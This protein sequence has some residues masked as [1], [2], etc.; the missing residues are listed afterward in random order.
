MGNSKNK[1]MDMLESGHYV[2][3]SSIPLPS[4]DPIVQ[5]VKRKFDE[6]S[7]VGIDTYGTTLADNPDGFYTWLND[8]QEELMDAV[9]YIQKIK[10]LNK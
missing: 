6:R 3:D 9:L 1:Y 8:I 2:T 4:S 7:A 5:A 10:D